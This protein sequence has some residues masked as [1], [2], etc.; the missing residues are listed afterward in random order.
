[1]LYAGS[2]GM[3]ELLLT[4][5]GDPQVK[6]AYGWTPLM[7]ASSK[8]YPTIVSSLLSHPRGLATINMS[9]EGKTAL[10]YAC[11]QGHVEIVRLLLRAG[12]D[13]TIT[14]HNDGADPKYIACVN[15]K[16]DCIHL[17]EVSV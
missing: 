10:W 12:A 16:I 17:L 15:G 4:S 13:P 1:V 5:G 8:G 6:S 7:E 14:R 9:K 3:V 11:S 2:V